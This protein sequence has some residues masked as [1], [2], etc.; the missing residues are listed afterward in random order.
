M[1]HIRVCSHKGIDNKGKIDK[2]QKDNIK[3]IIASEN[4]AK[5]FEASKKPLNLIA[6]FV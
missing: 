4:T 2:G 5:S 3:F 6:L 1:R